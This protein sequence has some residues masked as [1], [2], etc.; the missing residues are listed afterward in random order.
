M[1][2][3]KQSSP[4]SFATISGLSYCEAVSPG[5]HQKKY[6]WQNFE[7]TGKIELTM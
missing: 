3:E 1:S 5:N 4:P 6:Q 2:G 7:I